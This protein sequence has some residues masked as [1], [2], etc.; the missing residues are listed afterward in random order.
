MEL[1]VQW[2]MRPDTS[3]LDLYSSLGVATLLSRGLWHT[4][5]AMLHRVFSFSSGGPRPPVP[6]PPLLPPE[7]RGELAPGEYDERKMGNNGSNGISSDS[8][9]DAYLVPPPL[10]MAPEE[11]GLLVNSIGDGLYLLGL[12]DV[13]F[14]PHSS[15]L[16][17]IATQARQFCVSDPRGLTLAEFKRWCGSNPVALCCLERI[18]MAKHVLLLAR[19]MQRS[20]LATQD[21]RI[22]LPCGPLTPCPAP[23]GWDQLRQS[24]S[25]RSSRHLSVVACS[26]FVCVGGAG[27]GHQP[28][29]TRPSTSLTSSCFLTR[30]LTVSP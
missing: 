18:G 9:R 15:V 12:G 7:E 2:L 13:F 6:P 22:R 30:C 20:T 23:R 28:A 8:G 17:T 11:V 24:T 26:A 21:L 16:A 10:L 25:T 19:T 27:G 4:K 5:V 3:S 29:L 14:P 1:L